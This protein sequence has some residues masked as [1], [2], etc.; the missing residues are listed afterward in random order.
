[1]RLRDRATLAEEGRAPEP[2][3]ATLSHAS[4]RGVRLACRSRITP[5]IEVMTSIAA[6]DPFDDQLLAAFPRDES[7]ELAALMD[8]LRGTTPETWPYVIKKELGYGTYGRVHEARETVLDEPPPVGFGS[9]PE[10]TRPR[11]GAVTSA[12]G[13]GGAVSPFWA[14]AAAI[15]TGVARV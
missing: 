8:E 13:P 10:R 1:M 9:G 14:C 7:G 15:S 2:R 4:G 11:A 12:C 3:L 5:P 6:H